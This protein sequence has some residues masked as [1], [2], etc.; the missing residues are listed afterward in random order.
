V[1]LTNLKT[2]RLAQAMTQSKLA[3]QVH[4]AP[5]MISYL[6]SGKRLPSFSLACRLALVLGVGLDD[7]IRR[8]AVRIE[9]AA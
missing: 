9:H 2:I 3:E 8:E 7:L 1:I 5:S 6:E 4:V